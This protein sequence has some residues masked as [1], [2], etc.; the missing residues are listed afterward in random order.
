MGRALSLQLTLAVQAEIITQG[1]G[2]GRRKSL[3]HCV[4]CV[5]VLLPGMLG[6]GGS[7]WDNSARV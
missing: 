7:E 5:E 4:D 1:A 2:S 6:M 3:I